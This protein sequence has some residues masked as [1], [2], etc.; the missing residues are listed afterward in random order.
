M[1][2]CPVCPSRAGLVRRLWSAGSSGL[3][4]V[5][6]PWTPV[7]W[8]LTPGGAKPCPGAKCTI[9]HGIICMR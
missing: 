4:G 7:G 3:P 9:W 2:C 8:Q 6:L 5:S 1:Y